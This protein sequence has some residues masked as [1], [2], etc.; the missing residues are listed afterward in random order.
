MKM[1]YPLTRTVP[2]ARVLQR[3]YRLLYGA[4]GP[5]NWWPA[6][7]PFEIIVGAILTQNTA[8]TNV[9]KAIAN[10][11]KAG[12]M[13][14]KK[15]EKVAEKRLATVIKPSGY[16]NQKAKRL[17]IFVEYF[18]E[19][20]D[21]SIE[22]MAA[23]PVAEMRKELLELQ[24]VGPETADSILLYALEKPV[25]VIDN[26]TMR[27]FKRLGYLT[28]ED[29]YDSAQKMYMKHLK[30]DV[31]MYKE[32]HAL[33][34]ALGNKLCKPRPTCTSCPLREHIDCDPKL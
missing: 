27:T 14:P 22:K 3:I 21:Y 24:G 7:T 26:Y 33:I 23:R 16:F 8:W 2:T 29:D 5:M 6:D 18:G 25:F 19:K 30:L 28:N 31:T 20:Y 4:Y 34:V 12:L 32:Y 11:K 9:E 17:K 13:D 15:V 10:M 1:T